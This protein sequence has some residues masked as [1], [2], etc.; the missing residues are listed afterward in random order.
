MYLLDAMNHV[1]RI[2]KAMEE[3]GGTATINF[4]DFSMDAHVGERAIHLYPQFS[5]VQQGKVSYTTEFGDEV[6][7]FNGWYAMANKYWDFS[8]EKLKFKELVRERGLQTPA[9]FFDRSTSPR[10]VIIKHTTSSFGDTLRGPFREVGEHAPETLLKEGEYYE[11]FI[12]GLIVKVWYWN[13]KPICLKIRNMP[14]LECDGISTFGELLATERAIITKYH[15]EDWF[16]LQDWHILDLMLDYQ[17]VRVEDILP[18][19]H[20]VL[21]DYRYNNCWLKLTWVH[22]NALPTC[23]IPVV[24]DQLGRAGELLWNEIPEPMRQD[25]MF[26]IDAILD[27]RDCLW[28]LEINSNPQVHPDVYSSMLRD[29]F[30]RE[31]A[32]ENVAA[33]PVAPMPAAIPATQWTPSPQS[34]LPQAKYRS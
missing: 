2:K 19:G 14:T 29:L 28:L 31:P 18:A 24:R 12:F 23:D 11:Q 10:D 22:D 30:S 3:L 9:Y 21:L 16:D 5:K 8:S 32:Q 20:R 25:T 33:L 1:K 15:S 7:V 17:G 4:S 27:S 26:T 6:G 34:I 13:G